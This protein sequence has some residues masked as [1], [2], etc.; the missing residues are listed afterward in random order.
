MS[1]Q[2]SLLDACMSKAQEF[3]L[4]DISTETKKYVESLINENNHELIIKLFNGRIAFGTAGLRA[5]MGAGYTYMNDLVILQTSQGLADYLL[6]L[7][8]DQAKERGVIVGYDHR[9]YKL[10]NSLSSKRFAK[11]CSAVF[12][13][14]GFRVHILQHE[15]GI[16]TPLVAFGVRYLK[17]VAGFQVTASHNPA[18]DNGFKVY[19]DNGAQIIPPHDIEIAKHIENNL[20]P[21]YTYD[22]DNVDQ[23]ILAKDVTQD[24]SDAYFQQLAHLSTNTNTTNTNNLEVCYTAMHGVGYHWIQKAFLIY[25]HNP[26]LPVPSQMLPDPNFP[27]VSF[28]NPEE[29]GALNEAISFA[30]Q[31]DCFLIIAND[32]DADRLAVAEYIK[33]TKKWYSFTGNEIGAILGYWSIQQYKNLG[34]DLNNAAV[35]TSIVSVSI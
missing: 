8:G 20:V 27:T 21:H 32:P 17:C 2:V 16:A 4:Y 35:L 31:N 7:H 1:S 34:K 25:G 6:K 29:K 9:K 19:W 33:N 22:I 28:P 12:L 24:V 11:I 10:Y 14:H 5:E 15:N 18:K 23:H 30:D 3:I 26:L 13:Q